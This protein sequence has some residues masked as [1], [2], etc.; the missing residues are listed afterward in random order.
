MNAK[1]KTATAEQI[2]AWLVANPKSATF[3]NGTVPAWTDAQ[4][5]HS[6][7][8]YYPVL[9]GNK[10]TRTRRNH[11]VMVAQAVQRGWSAEQ[12][13]AASLRFAS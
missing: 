6:L 2:A 13:E 7:G 4:L 11:A 1:I 8:T 5:A 12:I 10:T 3:Y 9:A